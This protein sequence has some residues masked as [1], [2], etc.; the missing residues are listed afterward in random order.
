MNGKQSSTGKAL[1]EF[2]I[3]LNRLALAQPPRVADR[4]ADVK[5]EVR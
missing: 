1:A 5:P 3:A 2:L 4:P